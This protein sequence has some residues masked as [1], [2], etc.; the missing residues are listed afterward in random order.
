MTDSTT[1][2][3]SEMDFLTVFFLGLTGPAWVTV[4]MLYTIGY[5]L[6]NVTE[7]QIIFKI[8]LFYPYAVFFSI[9]NVLH[10]WFIASILFREF[11]KEFFTTDRCKRWKKS[12][13]AS[14]REL[15]DMIGGWL[16]ARDPDHY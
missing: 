10:N 2:K 1:S 8:L 4:Y 12:E 14:R 5:K 16:D 11:P 7:N 13:E 9:V 15:A 6:K 3:T